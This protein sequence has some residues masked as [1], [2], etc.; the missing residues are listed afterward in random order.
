MKVTIKNAKAHIGVH[1]GVDG[2]VLAG[3]IQ[4][5]TPKVVTNYETRGTRRTEG[6]RAPK[7]P[8]RV[9]GPVGGGQP[10]AVRGHHQP[11]RQAV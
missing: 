2:S 10:D 6:R 9:L 5:S 1:F 3:T 8:K 7:R 4:A 11:E